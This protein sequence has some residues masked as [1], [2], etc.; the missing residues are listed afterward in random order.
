LSLS[1]DG[2]FKWRSYKISDA[3]VNAFALLD[4]QGTLHFTWNEADLVKGVAR[5]IHARTNFFSYP[6]DSVVNIS[7]DYPFQPEPTF[8]M[9]AY[10]SL[11]LDPTDTMQIYWINW[12]NH[13]STIY[14]SVHTSNSISHKKLP[15]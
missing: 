9:G 13:N 11:V 12:Q 14:H 4:D 10:Q 5:T 8:W 2:A 1:S 3:A 15:W 7:G 6:F